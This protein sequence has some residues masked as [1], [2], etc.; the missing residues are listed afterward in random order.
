MSWK[1]YQSM[2]DNFGDNSLAGFVNYRRANAAM[3]NGP[4]GSPYTVYDEKFDDVDPLIKGIANTMPDGGFL[5]A[6]RA[7]VAAGRLPQVSWI[8]APET[9]CEH[10]G[11]SSPIQ[12]AYYTSAVLDALTATPDVW[13]RTVLLVDYDENDG[14]FD[15]APP[16]AAPALDADGQ[17][18]GDATCDV[19]A[20]RFTHANPPGTTEQ[21]P[22][23]GGVYGMGPRVPMIV[24][25]PW[26]K[27]GWVDS[28]VFDHTSVLQFL[29]RRFGVGEPNISPWRR[30][31]A[32]DLTSA[33]DFADPDRHPPSSLSGPSRG[34]ADRLRTAQEQLAQVAVPPAVDQTAPAQAT[35]TRP[36][37]ALPYDLQADAAIEP[38]S[39]AVQITF[40]NDGDAGAVFH[41][42]DLLHLDR[43]PRRYTVEAGRSLVGSWDTNADGGRYDLWLLGPHGFHRSFTGAIEWDAG[44]PAAEP[45]IVPQVAAEHAA[46]GR[47]LALTL[48]SR[49]SG[50]CTFTVSP[51]RVPRRRAAHQD[52]GGGCGGDRPVG[53]GRRGRLVRP[54]GDRRGGA[55][56]PPS[57]RRTPRE[58]RAG[59]ERPGDGD[60]LHLSDRRS[61]ATGHAQAVARPWS[62]SAQARHPNA[63]RDT[64][65]RTRFQAA[66]RASWNWW[67]TPARSTRWSGLPAALRASLSGTFTATVT[68]QAIRYSPSAATIQPIAG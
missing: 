20:E 19:A 53:R 7:D 4:D 28:Q 42:Y 57:F 32:G 15:H 47:R 54:H 18:A 24:V 22:P 38:G 55:G 43:I 29:E 56:V 45:A 68:T 21:P 48:A 25:S 2:P 58:R 31:V 9:Y 35:G 39:G 59:H 61:A 65:V 6:F 36:S 1:V 12:G 23:D 64:T 10:P 14:F 51:E 49:G 60:R 46:G 66:Q 50:A 62:T 44:A 37:R 13:A 8:V 52:P 30:A 40:S 5:E 41:V 16:P 27:G 11:P 33:F 3:G 26:S 67:R 17:P 63:P 34:D